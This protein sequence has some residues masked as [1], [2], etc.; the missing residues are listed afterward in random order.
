MFSYIKYFT[1]GFSQYSIMI[2]QLYIKTHHSM[3]WSAIFTLVSDAVV[4]A[5]L[6]VVPNYKKNKHSFAK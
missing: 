4:R 6:G 3:F 5:F 1:F 2:L